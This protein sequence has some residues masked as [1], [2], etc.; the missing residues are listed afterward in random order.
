MAMGVDL[1]ESLA[2]CNTR[3]A[4]VAEKVV[5]GGGFGD[6]RRR[7]EVDR[8]VEIGVSAGAVG[9]L[10]DDLDAAEHFE[11]GDP[12][13]DRPFLHFVRGVHEPGV[14]ILDAGAGTV[15]GDIPGRDHVVNPP[16]TIRQRLDGNRG[17]SIKA[18]AAERHDQ[19]G[20][21]SVIKLAGGGAA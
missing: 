15:E 17:V 18:G 20:Q 8:A 6:G 12:A 19:K 5:L 13:T 3:H 7:G 16:L 11:P 1:K 10:A 4:G 2:I 9:F 14:D 21:S